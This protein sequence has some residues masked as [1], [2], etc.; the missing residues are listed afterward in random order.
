MAASLNFQLKPDK[1]LT[2]PDLA[3]ALAMKALR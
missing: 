3:V 2:G 1:P